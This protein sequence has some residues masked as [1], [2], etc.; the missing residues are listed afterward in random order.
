MLG[1]FINLKVQK[2]IAAFLAITSFSVTL[3]CKIQN[4]SAQK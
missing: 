3:F 2:T 4:M 1:Q